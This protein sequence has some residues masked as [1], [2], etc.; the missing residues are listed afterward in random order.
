MRGKGWATLMAI[1][2]VLAPLLVPASAR[3]GGI[4]ML[5]TG[6]ALYSVP[7]TSMKEMRF[8]R[9]IRQRFDFSCGSAAVAM[10][11]TYQYG[12]PVSEQVVFEAMYRHGNQEKIRREGFSLL[13]IKRYLES[14]GFEA[15]GFEQP[16]DALKGAHLPAIVLLS[17]NG[18]HHFVVVKGVQEGRVLVGD[19]AM[20]TRAIPR[21]SFEGMWDNHL[22][23]VIHNREERAAFNAGEDWR[24][25][26]R[27][28]LA[29]GVERSGLGDIVIPK[30]GPGDF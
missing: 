8:L 15:D 27:A 10:L 30:H 23:F 24:V 13:D 2:G 7:V 18:Y 25:A 3:A 29:E 5:G 1:A 12:Y 17:E 26:P 22:L 28:P 16:L 6:G 14:L 4:D 20:G 11:L 21:A 9:T 19:P